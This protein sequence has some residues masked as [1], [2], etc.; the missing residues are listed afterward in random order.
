MVERGERHGRLITSEQDAAEMDAWFSRKSLGGSDPTRGART[1][2][3]DWDAVAE[4]WPA[5][6]D[7]SNPVADLARGTAAALRDG[8]A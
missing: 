1:A 8:I 2:A 6:V 5:R 7:G 4:R 3:A